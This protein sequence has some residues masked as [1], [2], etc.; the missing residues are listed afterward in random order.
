MEDNTYVVGTEG[1]SIFKCSI[2]QPSDNDISHFFEENTGVRWK[3]EAI[4]LLSNLPS[5]VVMEVKRRVERYVKD[6][7]EKDVW[8]PTVYQSKPDVKL[9]FPI[10]FNANYEKHMGPVLGISC[11]PF[12]KRLF[13]SCSTDGAVRMYDVQN[14]RPVTVFEPGYNEYLMAVAWS[15]FRSTVF[16]TVSNSGTVYIYDL[17]LS[18]QSPSYVIEYSTGAGQKFSK[19]K[20]AYS[21]SF[22]PRQ[23]DFLAI[24]YH[25]GCTKVF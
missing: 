15:P 4:G 17:L 5:K 13:L 2:S 14:H 25:D 11:S 19:H 6:K 16:V 10:P 12:I 20:T 8:A 22:N 24:G 3:Q 23:R 1:G 7:G 9:L 21:I 18:K